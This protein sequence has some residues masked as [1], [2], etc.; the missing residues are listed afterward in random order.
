M[1]R[2]ATFFHEPITV[3]SD[4]ALEKLHHASMALGERLW[5][6]ERQVLGG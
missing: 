4:I 2:K 3:C 6:G 1:L 5:Q